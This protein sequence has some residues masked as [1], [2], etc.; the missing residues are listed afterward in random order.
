MEPL[1]TGSLDGRCGK[2]TSRVAAPD[3]GG[4]SEVLEQRQLEFGSAPQ[5]LVVRLQGHA[6]VELQNRLPGTDRVA[7][8]AEPR[9]LPVEGG[10]EAVLHVG[11]IEGGLEAYG[12]GQIEGVLRACDSALIVAHPRS[13]E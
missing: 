7:R 10:R 3:R 6:D 12:I 4:V 8:D 1:Y 13:R 5:A 11:V 2:M 9:K